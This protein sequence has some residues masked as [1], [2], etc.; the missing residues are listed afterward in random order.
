VTGRRVSGRR[1]RFWQIRYTGNNDD[2]DRS[3]L[4][5]IDAA[6][7]ARALDAGAVVGHGFAQLVLERHGSPAVDDVRAIL[8]DLGHGPVIGS[9]ER[10]RLLLQDYPQRMSDRCPSGRAVPGAH[11]SRPGRPARR[12][13]SDRPNSL[14]VNGIERLPADPMV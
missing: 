2:V 9:N 4:I 12:G 14:G 10:T 7:A 3:R 11:R 1:R 8:D 6:L 5:T 13:R